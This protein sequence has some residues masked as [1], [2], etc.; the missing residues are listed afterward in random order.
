MTDVFRLVAASP[1]PH[2]SLSVYFLFRRFLQVLQ[3]PDG[4]FAH[5]ALGEGEAAEE[6]RQ[7]PEGLAARSPVFATRSP[8][9]TSMSAPLMMMSGAALARSRTRRRSLMF[10]FTSSGMRRLPKKPVGR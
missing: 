7:A 4:Q 8:G 2:I 3:H 1:C 9:T 6:Q 10:F 5:H